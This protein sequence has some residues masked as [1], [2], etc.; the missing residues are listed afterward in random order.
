[1]RG[2]RHVFGLRPS[3]RA[4][5][6][7]LDDGIIL[8]AAGNCLVLHSLEARTQRFIQVRSTARTPPAHFIGG[9]LP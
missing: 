9:P 8:F 2:C 7:V 6:H 3:V 4:G 5:L 1:M